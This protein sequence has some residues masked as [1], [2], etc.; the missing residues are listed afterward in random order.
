MTNHSEGKNHYFWQLFSGSIRLYSIIPPNESF[1]WLLR[2]L[3]V[4]LGSSAAQFCQ[5]RCFLSKL[6]RTLCVVTG[7]WQVLL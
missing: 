7:S 1:T 6:L 3:A 4:S 5:T 2:T